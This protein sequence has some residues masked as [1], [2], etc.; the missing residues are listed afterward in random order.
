MAPETRYNVPLLRKVRD[1]IRSEQKHDQKLWARISRSVLRT[2]PGRWTTDGGDRFITVSCPTAAC[3]AGWA[4][5]LSGALMLVSEDEYTWHSIRHGSAEAYEVL[6]A[7]GN[8]KHIAAYARE[9]LGLTAREAEA[10][11]DGEWSNEDTLENLSDIILAAQH[12]RDWEIRWYG[13]PPDDG[14]E[15][16]QWEQDLADP[17]QG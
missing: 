2:I 8:V 15:L 13:A 10:L 16:D 6:D 7:D 5:S 17:A 11:F 9:A 1:R 3:V 12:G 14:C 4:A